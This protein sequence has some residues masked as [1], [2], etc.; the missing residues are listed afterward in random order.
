MKNF[1]NE[2][3]N[4]IFMI[5]PELKKHKKDLTRLAQE[6][7]SHKPDTKFNEN[8]AQTL[9][10][11]L[12]KR[13]EELKGVSG[14]KKSVKPKGWSG[15]FINKFAYAVGGAIIMLIIIIP[16]LSFN[17]GERIALDSQP[18]AVNFNQGIT[19]VSKNAFGSLTSSLSEALEERGV[20]APGIGAGGGGGPANADSSGELLAIP[21]AETTVSAD[22]AKMIRPEY[23]NYKYSY[24]G[25]DI[26]LNED[27]MAVFKRVSSEASGRAMA[28]SFTNL[29]FDLLDLSQFK[30]TQ[31]ANLNLNEDREFGY[32]IYLNLADNSLDISQN[33]LK[34]PQ[35]NQECQNLPLSENQA[36]YERNRLT[37]DDVPSDDMI[38][39]I[40][41]KFVEDYEVDTSYFGEPFVDKEWRRTYE[42]AANKGS[43]WVPEVISVI[44]PA[45]IDG[46]MTYDQ[47]GNLSGMYVGVNIRSNKASDLH[48]LKPHTFESSQYDVITD[49]KKLVAL[50]EQGG[51]YPRYQ[52]EEAS[53]TVTVELGTPAL[54][55]MQ[56]WKYEKGLGQGEELFIPALIF[57][58]TN[59]PD[60]ENYYRKNIIIPL[61]SDMIDEMR[62]PVGIPE[63]MPLLK[64]PSA[65]TF[66]TVGENE[67]MLS[68]ENK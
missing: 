63:P 49:R 30:N 18:L 57:P 39:S 56:Y 40:A 37:I 14:N 55:L 68:E 9:K 52:Y 44:Y 23:V 22:S 20:S 24:I 61:I 62:P 19:S 12:M 27:T 51:L 43:A 34:W 7:I 64:S 2:I 65:D 10:K 53:K 41:S 54:G 38:L 17:Q 48:S 42:T 66:E 6:L 58:I 16:F 26:K 60:L 25:D 11:E 67:S 35:P 13:A 21:Q 28:Q 8:F 29:N 5:D 15:L 1:I 31:V 46:K 33:W 45:I 32:S 4:D 3:L 36:C 50:A 47:G 59:L